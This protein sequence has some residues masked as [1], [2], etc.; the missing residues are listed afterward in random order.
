MMRLMVQRNYVWVSAT[1]R[2]QALTDAGGLRPEFRVAEDIELWF[3]ILAC[4]YGMVR[5]GDG[6]LGV[7][8]DRAGAL[9]GREV[10][11][12]DGLRRVM[13]VVASNTRIPPD[14]RRLAEERAAGLDRRLEVLAG[15]KRGRQM[16]FAAYRK[17]GALR[18]PLLNRIRWRNDA[19]DDVKAAFPDLVRSD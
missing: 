10:E 2:R 13:L 8:R 12:T 6:V 19:P 17:L 7:K 4:G 15:N 11:M 16:L 5:A 14:V 1:I 18:R 3:R 9:S